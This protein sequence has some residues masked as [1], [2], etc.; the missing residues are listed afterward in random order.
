MLPNAS[1]SS[2]LEQILRSQL[3][4]FLEEFECIF[5]GADQGIFEVSPCAASDFG[6]SF[7]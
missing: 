5:A 7:A 1:V 4:V 6:A 3:F 2:T